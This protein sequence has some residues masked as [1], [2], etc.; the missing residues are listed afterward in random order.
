MSIATTAL[1]ATF[2]KLKYLQINMASNIPIVMLTQSLKGKKNTAK[3]DIEPTKFALTRSI[4]SFLVSTSSGDITNIIESNAQK[5][6]YCG[7]A[8]KKL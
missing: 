5:S 7:Y 8:M 2:I 1:L 3:P 4:V 6:S